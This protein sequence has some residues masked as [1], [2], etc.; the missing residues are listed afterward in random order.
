M[1][2]V[3]VP[4]SPT[5]T[6]GTPLVEAQDLSKHFGGLYAVDRMSIA[7]RRGELLGLIGPNGAGKTTLFNLLAGSLKPDA[8]SILVAG[9]ELSRKGPERR[10]ELGV[11]RTFQI[12]KPF[13]EMTVLENV[14]TGGQRQAGEGIW[15][16]FLRPGHV[17][18]QE[19]AAV[20]KARA[21]LDFVTLSHLEGE[22]ARVLSGGQR[23][24]LELARILMADPQAILLDEPAAGVNPTLLELII[25][26]VLELNA[27]GKSIL[28]I[29]HNMEMVSRLCGRVV[30]MAQGRYLTEGTP[31]DVARD[32]AVVDAYLGG[33]A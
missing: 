11:G 6:N 16:N 5:A 18:A 31:A 28:L 10:I 2:A 1:Q 23:K 30:V 12:P 20:E 19:Q 26:R 21:L 4:T 29:E 17:A 15:M 8:G 9:E 25:E 32:R 27:Q 22:P 33:V 13:A 7:L 24:L 14:L 3:V